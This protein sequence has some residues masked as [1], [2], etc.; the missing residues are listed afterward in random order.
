MY[1]LNKW[2]VLQAAETHRGP[3]GN[4]E[5][6]W[7]TRTELSGGFAGYR[8]NLSLFHTNHLGGGYNNTAEAFFLNVR[9]RNFEHLQHPLTVAWVCKCSVSTPTTITLPSYL[10]AT[11]SV[12]STVC[13]CVWFHSS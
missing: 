9:F 2:F 10:P 8:R 12:L 11:K 1:Y 4:R 6:I 5:R 13:V 3:E 7:P